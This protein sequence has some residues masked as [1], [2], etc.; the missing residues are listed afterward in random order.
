ML[1]AED[2]SAIR[3]EGVELV[4]VFRV[5]EDA[6]AIVVVGGE[7]TERIRLQVAAVRAEVNVDTMR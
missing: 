5:G 2:L 6:V 3:R 1:G 4:L 7:I